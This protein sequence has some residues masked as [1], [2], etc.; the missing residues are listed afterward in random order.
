[1]KK[2]MKDK[3]PIIVDV[4]DQVIAAYGGVAATQARFG[5]TEPMG[6][7]N[8]RSRGIPTRLLI[9]IHAETGISID[10]LKQGSP[11]CHS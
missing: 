10:R 3:K 4:V 9:D 6:V 7:Y 5:Y 2:Q 11:L 1:M 8:W